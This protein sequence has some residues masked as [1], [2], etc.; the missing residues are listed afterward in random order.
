MKLFIVLAMLP[1]FAQTGALKITTSDGGTVTTVL[2]GSIRVNKNSTLHRT[3]LIINDP[4]R[5]IQLSSDC[6]INTVYEYDRISGKYHFQSNG[7][8]KSTEAIAAINVTFVLYDAFGD[9]MKSLRGVYIE[10]VPSNTE[11][12]FQKLGAGS[13][14]AS[15]NEVESLLTVATFVHSVRLY[16]GKVWRSDLKAIAG[17]LAKIRLESGSGVLEPEKPKK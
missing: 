7:S 16:S 11:V 3:W 10:D 8:L 15:E 5:P 17:E 2:S 6:G 4:A 14:Y 1:F 9:H 12:T 13:W